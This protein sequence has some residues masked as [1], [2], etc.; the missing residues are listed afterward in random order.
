MRCAQPVVLGFFPLDEELQLVPGTLTPMVA[1]ALVRLG[2]WMPFERSAGELQYFMG[3]TVS[4]CKAR[5]DTERAGAAYVAVQSAQAEQIQAELPA[6]PAGVERQYLGL[7]GAFVGLVGG[8]WCEVKTL[9]LGVIEAG[10]NGEVHTRDLSYFS[11]HSEASEFAQ[12]A[13]VETHRRGL[14]SSGVVCA[15]TDGAEWIQGF[16]DRHRQDARRILDFYH[17]AEHVAAAGRAVYG[18]NTPAF[19]NWFAVQRRELRDGDPQAVLDALRQLLNPAQQAGQTVSESAR[20]IVETNLNYLLKRR[21]QIAYAEF[22]RAGYPI[23]SGAGEACHKLV[24][25]SRLKGSGMRWAPANVNPMAAL[26]NLVCNNRWDEGWAAIT[27]YWR[28]QAMHRQTER[29]AARA[30][31]KAA[32]CESL[33]REC[34][35]SHASESKPLLPPG[36]KLR[37]P[38]RWRN[39]NFIFAKAAPSAKT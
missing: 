18:E 37:S 16:V 34:Q 9:S 15:V 6:P 19:E 22:Q 7:D 26:R 31:A 29:R 25:A 5:R 20:Q 24:I 13:V 12:Q 23:G 39:H 3:V 32:A 14:E 28:Q 35:P 1:E 2:A 21:D 4:G 36:F 17:A 27:T 11:R 8:E 33:E 38:G 10:D 30:A